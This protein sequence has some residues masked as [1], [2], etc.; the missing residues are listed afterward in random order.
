[1]SFNKRN[2]NIFLTTLLIFVLSI[3]YLAAQEGVVLDKIAGAVGSEIILLSDIESQLAYIQSQRGRIS[4]DDKCIIIE[5]L[6]GQN[7]MLHQARLDSVMVTD[8][9]VEAQINTRMDRILALMN[10]DFQQFE[11][12]YGKSVSEVRSDFRDPLRNQI[13][14]ERM[15]QTIMSTI[16][17]T[18]SE[19]KS[20]FNRVPKDSLPYFNAEV[21]LAEIIYYPKVNEDEKQ[22][23]YAKISKIRKMIVEEGQ[24]FGKVASTY[25]EDGG[26]A[27]LGG[28][29]GWQKRGT[30]VPEFEA[31]AYNLEPGEISDIFE[32]PF[33]Y[34]FLELIDRRGSILHTRHVLITPKI[35]ELDH[36]NALD[37]LDSLITLMNAGDSTATFE[38][39]LKNNGS[40]NTQSFHNGGRMMNPQTGDTFFEISDL[41]PG[42]F[43]V[44]DTMSIGNVSAPIAREEPSGKR[45]YQLIRL[46]SRSK[47]HKASLKTDYSRIQEAALQEKKSKF[48]QNWISEHIGNTYVEIADE[49]RGCPNLDL[50][51]KNASSSEKP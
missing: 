24:E 1:M 19:V 49:Y 10:N 45:Y 5:S 48:L 43:F 23:A 11:E 27:R 20:F 6:L 36:L 50:W 26:S 37:Y 7:L 22:I 31:V 4:P 9:E 21:E 14:T 8:E 34:H 16:T 2:T 3:G 29:L 47:P 39:V 35:T 42:L 18:P 25:S 15:Q 12:Y 51:L 46:M 33:G 28:D 32:S 41:D 38:M 13:L 44:I 30:F 40:D 17:I